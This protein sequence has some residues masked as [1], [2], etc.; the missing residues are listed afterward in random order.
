MCN[1]M[2]RGGWYEATRSNGPRRRG[3]VRV[4]IGR[5]AYQNW[6]RAHKGRE[7]GAEPKPANGEPLSTKEWAVALR[8]V[9]LGG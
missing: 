4:H 7:R 9:G 8:V 5:C 2:T 3:G 1:S 6:A